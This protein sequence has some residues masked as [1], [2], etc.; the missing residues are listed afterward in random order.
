MLD[1][2]TFGRLVHDLYLR[3][4]LIDI[5][6]ELVAKA[7]RPSPD[8]EAMGHI[9]AIERSLYDLASADTSGE[10]KDFRSLLTQAAR[11]S[12]AAESVVLRPAFAL[13]TT[14]SVAC[15]SQT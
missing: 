8:I 10:A 2:V 3:R 13:S 6:E 5:G 7:Y 11:I 15:T 14:C 9:E 4:K 12:A 1:A